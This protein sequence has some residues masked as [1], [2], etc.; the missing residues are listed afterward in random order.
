MRKT[1][2]CQTVVLCFASIP[3]F[4]A[5]S[6]PAT[7]SAAPHSVAAKDVLS[8]RERA[9]QMLNRFSFGARPG[10]VEQIL[11]SGPD[12]AMRW[13]E[14]Q[15]NPASLADG[16]CD[17]RMAEY[18]TL[19]MTPQQVLQTFPDRGA[20]N[21]TAD[22]KQPYP[23]DPNLA[24][25]YEAQVSKLRLERDAKKNAAIFSVTP[26]EKAAG[27]ATALR[28]AG[29]LFA[30]PKKERM[31][32]LLKL[33]V[34]DRIA[35]ATY[36]QGEQRNTLLTD[37]TPREREYFYTLASGG[38]DASFRALQ[39]LSEARILRDILTERQLQAVMTDFWFNHFNI[40]GPKDQDRWYMASYE[41]DVIRRYAL[42]KF[43]DLLMATA[44]SP[45]MMVY[46]DNWTSI[47]P[48]SPANV[49]NGKKGSRGLNENYAREVME[50]HTLSVNGGYSQADVTNLA[51]VLTGWSIDH[52]ELGGG[53]QFDAKKHEP[54]AK[55]WFGQAIPE[56][57][58]NEGITALKTLAN[59]PK[60]A[61][62][63][64][65]L[66]AQRFLA[67][68]PPDAV[69]DRMS[70]TYMATGGDIK[71]ML[72]T[73]VHSAEFNS[74][75][76]Y[77]NKMKTPVEFVASVYRTTATDPSNAGALVQTVDRMGQGLYKKIEP[78]GYYITAEH[79]I[80]TNA[81]LERLNFALQLT[82]DHYAGQKFAADRLLALGLMSQ[83]AGTSL[84]SLHPVHDEVTLPHNSLW[85][86]SQ[87]QSAGRA[88]DA[89]ASSTRMDSASPNEM[90]VD[91]PSTASGANVSATGTGA[92]L[93]L[94]VLENSLVGSRVASKT[95]QL[96]LEQIRKPAT[97]GGPASA[98][99]K[100]NLLTAL[101]IGSP[102]FQAR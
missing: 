73:L 78:T 55:Q 5:T 10:E 28:V 102:E 19:T 91:L 12:G 85:T 51:S 79:W 82:S 47:G 84:Q 41:R 50:L 67:D 6:H 33:P 34:Q 45:A 26:E 48:G 96:I 44:T 54:G 49:A 36:V 88:S 99:E 68:A 87:T 83:P 20:I 80:N 90:R 53:F 86:V 35:F 101:V 97:E 74:P 60:T 27:A 70:A 46:L 37:F 4:A 8:E 3:L 58:A 77:R 18:P 98:P 25:V 31:A 93:S 17:R 63:I 71:E 1:F 62:F 65:Y 29:Q 69:V 64:S 42:G 76:Y 38:P 16:E 95:N 15:L 52:P 81:L 2:V 11:A 61:H 89:A 23:N 13:F 72:R 59:S 24:A 21:R 9:Q 66:L 92:E 32:F 94:A 39:E 75:L 100:L 56:G 14:A 7:K 57:G 43:P 30:V 22:G 40:Y